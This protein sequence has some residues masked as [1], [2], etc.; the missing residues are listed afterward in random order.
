MAFR[1]ERSIGANDLAVRLLTMGLRWACRGLLDVGI[2]PAVGHEVRHY[3]VVDGAEVLRRAKAEPETYGEALSMYCDVVC[4]PPERRGALR[5]WPLADDEQAVFGDAVRLVE[6]HPGLLGVSC[7]LDRQYGALA[8]VLAKHAGPTESQGRLER[9]CRGGD[10]LGTATG[11]QGFAWRWLG[12]D[13]AHAVA[14]DL[15]GVDEATFS[16]TFAN[17]WHEMRSAGVYKASPADSDAARV[18]RW[19]TQLCGFLVE[20]KAFYA[21]VAERGFG[22]LTG[23]D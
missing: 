6:A 21:T 1:R 13:E 12:R 23:T 20:L 22:V 18:E 11:C 2:L 14:A 7:D 19:R 15:A 10:P 4:S 8:H 5:P 17:C 9:A 16:A 3:A